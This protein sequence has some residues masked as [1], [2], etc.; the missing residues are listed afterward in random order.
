[1]GFVI[2]KFIFLLYN[3]IIAG[4]FM[5]T[6]I[7]HRCGSNTVTLDMIKMNSTLSFIYLIMF[8]KNASFQMNTGN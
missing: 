3:I 7:A 8:L 6:L 5:V 1:M 2:V 4:L